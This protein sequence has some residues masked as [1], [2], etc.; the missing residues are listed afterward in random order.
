M[1]YILDDNGEPVRCDSLLAWAKWYEEADRR[2]A[3]DKVGDYVVST[4]FLAVDYGWLPSNKPI[5]WESMAFKSGEGLWCDRCGGS[6]EQAEAMHGDMIKHIREQIREM[7]N[8]CAKLM[9]DV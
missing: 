3:Y 6:R 1:K 5:L 2:V 4:I 8:N 7:K 9:H